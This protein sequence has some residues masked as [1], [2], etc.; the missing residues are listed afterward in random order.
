M[1]EPPINPICN[2]LP[3]VLMIVGLEHVVEVALRSGLTGCHIAEPV[4]RLCQ[5]LGQQRVDYR[6]AGTQLV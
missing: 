1:P 5:Q 2:G 3:Q 6:R 4:N